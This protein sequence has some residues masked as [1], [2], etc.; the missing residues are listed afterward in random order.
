MRKLILLVLMLIGVQVAFAGVT[1]PL[2]TELN[3]LEGESGRFKFQVQAI[4]SEQDLECTSSLKENSV[5]LVDFDP[6]TIVVLAGTVKDIYG[7]V[8]VPKE[9]GFG[10]FEENF[11]ISCKPVTGM[12]GAAVMVETCNLPIKVNVVAERTRDNMYIPPKPFPLMTLVVIV[13][14]GVLLLTI[15][16]LYIWNKKG[17]MQKK[18]VLRS[19]AKKTKKRR[20]K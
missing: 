9:L 15:V 10:T 13:V 18:T 6:E 3:L 16:F 2:P 8:E 20:K 7:T 4:T 14:V 11:C 19:G 17:S 1:N 12:T 5:L